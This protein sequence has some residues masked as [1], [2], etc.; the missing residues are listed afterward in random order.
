MANFDGK[1]ILITGGTSGIGLA[2]AVL[3]K[4]DG[5]NVLATGTNPERIAKL[6]SDHGIDAIANDA[7]DPA[8][9][10]TLAE[11]VKTRFGRLDGFF[12]NAGFGKFYPHTDVTP[13]AFAEQ[14]DVNVRGPLLHVRA[15]SPLMKDGA[16]VV[17]NTSVVNVMGM[18]GGSI[19]ASTKAALRSLTRVL[20]AE[21]AERNIRVNAVSP[22][23]IETD[24]FARTNLPEEATK[25][26]AEQILAQVPLRRFGK[27][28]EVAR[29]ARFLLSDDASFVTG[30]E[31]EVDGGMTQV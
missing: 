30:S 7:G 10:D 24:F 12:A 13:E 22:G 19:Y 18:P 28:E 21:L 2:T 20:A 1:N 3:L 4:N 8:A 26:F 25:G 9:A 11:E 5:A 29:V 17:F 16:A 15:L 31:Y 23:P 27:S 6:Q 14:Y